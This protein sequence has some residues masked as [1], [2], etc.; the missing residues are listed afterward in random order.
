[1][2]VAFA[3]GAAG[4]TIAGGAVRGLVALLV[5]VA[6]Y[7]GLIAV[8][9]EGIRAIG[10]T[11]AAAVWGAV[12]VVAGPL[13]GA[14]G[15]TWRRRTGWRRAI[16]V[17]PMAGTLIAEGLVFGVWPPWPPGV[18]PVALVLAIEVG[19]GLALPLVL[20]RPGERWRGYVATGLF[21]VAAVATLPVLVDLVRGIADRF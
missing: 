21:A 17:A 7:Y 1:V 3:A 5:A 11:H 4:R 9:G 20:L 15:E 10:A 14:A 8:L 12:A 19:L 13:V 2:A 18:D 16:A 6:V